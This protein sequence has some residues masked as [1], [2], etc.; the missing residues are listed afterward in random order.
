[1]D[2]KRRALTPMPPLPAHAE[3]DQPIRLVEELDVETTNNKPVEPQ[4]IKPAMCPETE[5]DASKI[6][7]SARTM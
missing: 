1:M 7:P 4:V 5:D 2:A 6:T 3:L